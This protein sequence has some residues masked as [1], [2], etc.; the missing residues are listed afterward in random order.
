[1]NKIITDE[2]LAKIDLGAKL[3][4]ATETEA[5]YLTHTCLGDTELEALSRLGL[6][7]IHVGT[8]LR[9]PA[10]RKQRIELRVSITRDYSRVKNPVKL[11]DPMG[12]L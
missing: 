2:L 12:E 6:V 8:E 7:I 1:M 3:L 11:E 5:T 9:K 10:G 4:F